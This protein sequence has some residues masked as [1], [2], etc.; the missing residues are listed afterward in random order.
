MTQQCDFFFPFF[1]LGAGQVTE[2]FKCVPWPSRDLTV[3]SLRPNYM[4][5]VLTVE[6]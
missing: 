4:A 6:V 5:I 3:Q 2:M 1:S